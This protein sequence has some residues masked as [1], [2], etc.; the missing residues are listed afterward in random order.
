MS[1]RRPS[2]FRRLPS[3]L[4]AL[5]LV[6]TAT[7]AAADPVCTLIVDVANAV[8][9]VRTGPECD[10]RTSPASSFKVALS[11]MGFES[12][13]LQDAHAPEWPYRDEYRAWNDAWKRPVDPTAWLRDSVVWYSQVLTTTM[14]QARFKGYVDALGYG[15]RDI[16][17]DPG[18]T[19]G[20]TRAWLSSSLQISPAEQV[21]MLRRLVR[22]E[23]PFSTRA[24]DLTMATMPSFAADDWTVFGKTGTG[25]VPRADGTLDDDRAFGWFV[26]WA[27]RGDRTVV[28]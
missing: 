4:A 26:G 22:H 16:T 13:I 10:T 9:L 5:A 19:N 24:H 7:G 11:L 14:G 8:P 15:N 1:S 18:T 6:G 25:N 28:F 20:L 21:T 12:G 2:V 3:C 17:G 27:R 23:L